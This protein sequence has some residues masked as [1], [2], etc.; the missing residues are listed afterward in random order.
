LVFKN[1]VVIGVAGDEV[2]IGVDEFFC[3][4]GDGISLLSPQG[5]SKR[6]LRCISE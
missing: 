3:G 1:D 2:F 5:L 4:C 6:T